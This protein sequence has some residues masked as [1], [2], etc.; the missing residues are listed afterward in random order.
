MQT[1]RLLCK[2]WLF[3]TIF[4]PIAITSTITQYGV[5]AVFLGPHCSLA[6]VFCGFIASKNPESIASPAISIAVS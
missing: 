6:V 1:G 3:P 2:T 5:S 4:F